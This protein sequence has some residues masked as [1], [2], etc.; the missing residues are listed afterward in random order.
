MP[1][2]KQ[3]GPV[4]DEKVKYK[5]TDPN[6]YNGKHVMVVGAGNSAIEAAIRSG[7]IVL[8][9]APKSSVGATT[10]LPWSFAISKAI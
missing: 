3:L 5:L 10:S 8:K 2:S 4:E 6:D 1:K 7:R 9:T